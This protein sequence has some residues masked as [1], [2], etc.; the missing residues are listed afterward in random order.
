MRSG[1]T[2][3]VANAILWD[4]LYEIQKNRF[5]KKE[6]SKKNSKNDERFF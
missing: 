5:F 3:L 6:I 1:Q 2:L 4:F